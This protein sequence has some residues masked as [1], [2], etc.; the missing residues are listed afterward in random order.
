M[1]ARM[2]DFDALWTSGKL[3]KL[4]EKDRPEYMWMYG[5]AEA[6]GVFEAQPKLIWRSAYSIL[7][8]SV[9]IEEIARLLDEFER[10]KLLFRW[11]DQ[12]GRIL[13]YWIGSE[14]NGRRP[15]PTRMGKLRYPDPPSKKLKKFLST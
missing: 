9:T 3:G 1:P 12:F 5:M 8:P 7:R 10:V 13:G 4:E 2:I 6:N 14:K 11:T 15:P